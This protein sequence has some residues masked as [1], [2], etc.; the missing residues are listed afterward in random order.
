MIWLLF[1]ALD[2]KLVERHYNSAQTLTVDF[3]Q[4]HIAGG[5]HRSESGTL[6]L[7]KPGRMRWDYSNPPGKLFLSDG[8]T[9]WYFSPLA[10]RAEHS[11]VKESSDLRAPLAFLLGKL[12]F[13]RDFTDIR[14]ED[15]EI[16]AIPKSDRAP[17]REVRFTAEPSGVITRVKVMGR[18]AS[19]MEFVFQN[20][21]RNV[22]VKDSLFHFTPPSG[23]EVIEVAEP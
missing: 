4:I 23:A 22:P 3:E 21:H 11:K 20:E 12:D 15:G 9:L 14:E 13:N 16:V 17:Y 19:Q 1:L 10:N 6:T 7:R 8:K 18:D 2:L 5:R